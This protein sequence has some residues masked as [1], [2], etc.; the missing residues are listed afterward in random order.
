VQAVQPGASGNLA[1]GKIQAISGPLGFQLSVTN[2]S[3]TRYGL[4][5]PAPAPNSND[6]DRL[7]NQLLTSLR[8]TALQELQDRYAGT[9]LEKGVPILSSL[10]LASVLE[11]TYSPLDDSPAE[12]LQLSLRL[13]FKALE[14]YP[15][16]L[17]NL[18]TPLL[19]ASLPEG[20]TVL[21][22]TLNIINFNQPILDKENTAH[23]TLQAQRKIQAVIIPQ[24]VIQLA[25]GLPIEEARQHLL[26][27]LPIVEKPLIRPFP[28]WS[29]YM[30]FLPL[31][32]TVMVK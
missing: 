19:D 21:P 30:P 14:I 9:P 24:K 18:V 17:Q 6:R 26:N 27:H 20:F 11:K 23:W 4:D 7:Y 12:Q 10:R 2:L 31:R 25:R 22:D 16:D 28:S 32:I 3:P 13:E 8:Q 5:K 29:P 15:Q 1:A